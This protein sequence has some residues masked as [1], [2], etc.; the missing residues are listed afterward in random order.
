MRFLPMVLLLAACGGKEDT[1]P[2]VPTF[3][4]V[5]DEVFLVSC[6]LS[7]CHGGGTG[8]LTLDKDDPD[9]AY[10]ALV[11]ATGDSGL[12]LVVPGDVDG[13]YLIQ[14]LRDADGIEGDPMPPPFGLETADP[15]A[16]A[17]VIAWVEAG[18][19]ND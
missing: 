15:D 18:A 11:N 6:A 9:A 14:K 3:T 19:P 16:M 5:R 10:D 1:A 7:S 4:E 12:T 8:G 13:S 2:T 17:R